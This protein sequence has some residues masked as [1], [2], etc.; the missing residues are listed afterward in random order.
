MKKTAVLLLLLASLSFGDCK[1]EMALIG[2]GKSWNPSVTDTMNYYCITRFWW[3]QYENTTVRCTLEIP[4][5]YTSPP[6]WASTRG[7]TL[8]STAVLHYGIGII[9]PTPLNTV[10]VYAQYESDAIIFS[11][12]GQPIEYKPRDRVTAVLSPVKTARA[13]QATSK[14]GIYDPLGRRMKAKAGM[15]I[16]GGKMFHVER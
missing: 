12:S 11:Y 10:T 1:M 2:T 8:L 16:S 9:D 7:R 3:T 15:Y 4:I 6:E 13:L 5:R 14:K